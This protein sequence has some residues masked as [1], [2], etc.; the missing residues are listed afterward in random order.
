[1]R[2]SSPA[3]PVP[4]AGWLAVDDAAKAWCTVRRDVAQHGAVP[5]SESP[6][7]RTLTRCFAVAVLLCRKVPHPPASAKAEYGPNGPANDQQK[8]GKS[9]EAK[10]W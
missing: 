8:G 5:L 10:V 1:M 6:A 7:D 3:S 4:L 2:R 9:E